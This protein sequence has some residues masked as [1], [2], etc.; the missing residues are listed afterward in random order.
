MQYRLVLHE[1]KKT[2]LVSSS[3]SCVPGQRLSSQRGWEDEGAYQTDVQ[4][5]LLNIPFL[6]LFFFWKK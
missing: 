1:N 4:T 3:A 5:A 2:S 6:C